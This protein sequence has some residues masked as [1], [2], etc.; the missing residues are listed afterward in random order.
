MIGAGAWL[1]RVLSHPL[2]RG[3]DPDAA[4]APAI[5]R[6]IIEQKPL[7][8]G[9]Y[10]EW[11]EAVRDHVGVERPVLEIGSGAGYLAD[12]LPGLLTS[13]VRA[14]PATRVVLDAQR[15]PFKTA[16]LHGVA[17]TNVVHHLPDVTTFFHEAARTIAPGGV[18]VAIEPWVSTWS[19]FVYQKLHHEPFAP[20]ASQWAF[21]R[22]GP[23]SAA[24]GALPWI[25]FSR[26][27]DR[28]LADFPEWRIEVVRPGW[29]LR[30]LLSGG[31]S[32]RSLAPAGLGGTLRRLERRLERSP[33]RWA[34]FALVVLRRT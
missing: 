2:A 21:P 34:M 11:Y 6:R 16:S 27:R 28:F 8:R 3:L 24:N 31:V 13:D 19:R 1:R 23:L 14:T 22:G 10:E 29:P 26:D 33:E 15:L 17:M 7:L 25:L 30:Y 20:E 18:L 32:L 5:H 4:A 12:Y 9:V